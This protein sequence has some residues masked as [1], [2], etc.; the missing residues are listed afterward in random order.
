M[1]RLVPPAPPPPQSHSP[2]PHPPPVPLISNQSLPNPRH[3]VLPAVNPESRPVL[4]KILNNPNWR[5]LHAWIGSCPE[6]PPESLLIQCQPLCCGLCAVRINAQ[7]Q[8][9]QHYNGQTHAKRTRSY[10]Q[11]QVNPSS[12]NEGKRSGSEV[13]AVPTKKAK[14]RVDPQAL[15]CEICGCGFTSQTQVDIHVRG[16][17]HQRKLAGL[18]ELKRG[19]FNS[20]TGL[21]QREPRVLPENEPLGTSARNPDH[22]INLTADTPENPKTSGQTPDVLGPFFCNL[23]Q[24]SATSQM[25]LDLHLNGKSHR[26]AIKRAELAPIIGAVQKLN[27]PLK[28]GA[29]LGVDFS[30]FRTPSGQYYC[31]PCNISLNSESQ[32]AQHSASKK[33]KQ[34]LMANNAK[35]S[36]S[37]TKLK[38]KPHKKSSVFIVK[39]P[40]LLA[41]RVRSK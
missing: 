16:R 28:N 4:H 37:Q 29:C 31:A 30:S 36:L 22:L 9:Y 40:Q 23:C 1:A 13:N 26:K 6:P 21:W 7:S 20:K 34:T 18:P 5:F 3:P 41:H 39:Q 27:P 11:A 38:D 19:Y 10:W 8:A 35:S 2:I 33:H 12:S 17:N 32:F 25:Q 24:V 14:I 15:F